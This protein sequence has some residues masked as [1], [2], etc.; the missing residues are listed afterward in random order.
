MTPKAI[1]AV[2]LCLVAASVSGAALETKRVIWRSR[3]PVEELDLFWG[4]GSVERAPKPPFV[5][6]AED[7]SGTKPKLQVKDQAGVAWT[8]KL[9]PANPEQNEVHAE[10]AASRI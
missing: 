1:A 5:F 10:I 7:V 4:M 2:L 6:V 8:V 3:I 9:A